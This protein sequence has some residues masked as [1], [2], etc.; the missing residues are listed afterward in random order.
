M[1]TQRLTRRVR[2]MAAVV[3]TLGA[4]GCSEPAPRA[5][6]YGADACDH[7][8]MTIADPRFAAQL[9]TRTGKIF[10]FDDPRCLANFVTAAHV[11]SAAVHSIWLNDY[12]APESRVQ[13]DAAVFVTSDE[14]RA[15]MNGQTA[16]FA[17][18]TDAEALQRTVGGHLQSWPAFLKGAS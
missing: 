5:I 6:Q 3:A 17:A 7:C 9:V 10:R 8:R 18:R 13:A 2:H 16:A 15:P 12:G 4:V 11:P 14:I 1:F